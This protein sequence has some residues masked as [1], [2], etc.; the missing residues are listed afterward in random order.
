MRKFSI[1]SINSDF[2]IIYSYRNVKFVCLNSAVEAWAALKE[3]Q[4]KEL[5][6]LGQC[7]G[8]HRPQ[9]ERRGMRLLPGEQS[10]AR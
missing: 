4:Q 6:L 3:E 9:A 8:P 7:A 10:C 2:Y 1:I 5:L